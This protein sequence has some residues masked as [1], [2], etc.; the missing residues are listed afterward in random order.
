MTSAAET[1][2]Q[3]RSTATRNALLDATVTCLVEN[4]YTGTTG[5]AIARQA[6][7]S[8]GAQL[9]HFGTR[10]H[11]VVAA[12]EH[13]AKMR[14]A[15]V[16]EQLEDLEKLD[17]SEADDVAAVALTLLA[18]ALSGPLFAASLEL[19]VAARA[20]ASLRSELLPVERQVRVALERVCHDFI[21]ADPRRIQLTLD[22]LIGQGVAGLFEG[23]SDVR[24]RA[25]QH[26]NVLM[27]E[28]AGAVA[29]KA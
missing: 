28:S 7:L 21:T 12:V 16:R 22:L 9:H 29:Y 23:D 4:G 14:L 10:D 27:N 13:L 2:Q 24:R 26:W 20:N 19:W 5:P 17:G 25:R 1:R 15:A 18:E 11:L 8:R 3:A 6:G